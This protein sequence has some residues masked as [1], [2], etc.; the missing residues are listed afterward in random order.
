[1][2]I[3]PTSASNPAERPPATTTAPTVAA[4]AGT[5]TPAGATLIDIDH[6]DFFYG[7]SQALHDINLKI[8]EEGHRFH[9]SFR[10]PASLLCCVASTA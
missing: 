7:S 9:R 6:V 2:D 5:P 10:L 4:P 3:R 1:M 8:E